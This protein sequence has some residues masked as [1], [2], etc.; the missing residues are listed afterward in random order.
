M[1]ILSGFL[2]RM[3]VLAV[4]L[5]ISFAMFMYMLLETGTQVPLL[6]EKP[7]T[8]TL[9]VDN[10]DNLVPASQVQIAGVRVGG[11]LSSNATPQGGEV[12]F[13]IDSEHWP[14]HEGLKVRIG[15]RSL[16]GE[17]YLELHD[18][19]GAPVPEGTTL[20]R[21]AVLPLVTLYDVYDS[22]DAR[23]RGQT[24]D[25]LRS[26]G[27][28]TGQ[29]RDAVSATF[30]G[31]SALGRGGHTAIDAIA[32]QSQDLRTLTRQTTTLLNALDTG[33]GQIAHMVSAANR[34]TGAT[35]GQRAALEDT[36]RLLPDTA[37]HARAASG[38]LTELAGA[39]RPVAADLRAA[40]PK[41]TEALVELPDTTRDLR[42]LLMPAN[43]VLDRA[44]R[45]LD[46]VEP[47]A[48]D[49][50]DVVAPTRDVLA[51]VN[52]VV[53]YLRPYGPDLAAFFANF[54]ATLE[55]TDEAGR[56]YIQAMLFFNEKTAAT[57]VPISAGAYVNAFP[58]A[59]AGS[60]P[61]P[62]VGQYPRVERAPR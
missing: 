52:P 31:L 21:D 8:L 12:V 49:V 28:A 3:V 1:K 26:L 17:T 27:A 38:S 56:H 54:S 9:H 36:L 46:R 53:G 51:D 13:K 45:T 29:T 23:T 39:L 47:F 62:F 59:G 50:S 11:V 37:D 14:M 55:Q 10:I 48:E 57:P 61:G 24:T 42:G 41:L 18:G 25:M 16:V 58:K 2:G 60:K 40:G 44:P 43:S 30:N 32:A 5:A 22:L 19:T 7:K 34:V 35:A 15:Q 4:F 6:Q 33:E 20:P